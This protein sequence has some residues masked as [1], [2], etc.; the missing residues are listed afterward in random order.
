MKVANQ[1]IKLSEL[2]MNLLGGKV[3]MSGFYNTAGTNAKSNLS[4]NLDQMGIK[5]SANSFDMFNSYAPVLKNMT[6]NF[7]PI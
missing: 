6:G 7:S 1:E 3:Q 4:I 2:N 5:E